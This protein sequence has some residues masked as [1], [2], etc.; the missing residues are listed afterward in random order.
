MLHSVL[1]SANGNEAIKEIIYV[2]D[3]EGIGLQAYQ[4]KTGLKPV[5]V[6]ANASEFINSIKDKFDSC[7]RIVIFDKCML[8][9]ELK[10]YPSLGTNLKDEAL[11]METYFEEKEDTQNYVV[12]FYDRYNSLQNSGL[13]F[14]NLFAHRIC[15]GMS[16]D[17]INKN[18][19]EI[20]IKSKTVTANRAL[21]FTM[22]SDAYTWFRP[23]V[24]PKEE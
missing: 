20:R 3:G 4:E 7:G 14:K 23:Y 24:F 2:G 10:G 5:T 9:K 11:L 13:D 22:N 8:K 17:E 21:Y 18:F 15:F 1:L 19:S 6:Y 16:V 12:A